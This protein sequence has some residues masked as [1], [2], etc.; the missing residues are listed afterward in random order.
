MWTRS[1]LKQNAKNKLVNYYWLGVV[2]CLI[3]SFLGGGGGASSGAT[4]SMQQRQDVSYNEYYDGY[5]GE[6]SVSSNP[7]DRMKDLLKQYELPGYEYTYSF[8]PLLV[9]NLTSLE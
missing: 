2:V 4:Q 1:Q 7:V 3:L 8:S 9:I 5:A 6:G